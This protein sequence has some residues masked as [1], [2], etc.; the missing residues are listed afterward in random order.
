MRGKLGIWKDMK[1]FNVWGLLG[2]RYEMD[3][4]MWG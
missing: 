2:T 3:G 1:R 4:Q